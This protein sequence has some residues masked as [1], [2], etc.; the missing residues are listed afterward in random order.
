[1]PARPD[2]SSLPPAAVAYIEALEAELEH[3]RERSRSRSA[4]ADAGASAAAEPAEP[5]TTLQVITISA[6]GAA[7]R[8][9]RH[10]YN[11]QRRGGMGVFDLETPET[12]P[13][14]FLLIADLNDHLIFI[15]TRARGLR[16]PVDSLTETAVRGRGAALSPLLGLAAGEDLAVVAPASG[17]NYLNLLTDRG[18]V[19]RYAAHLFGP[20]MRVGA[21]LYDVRESGAPVA[22]CWSAGNEDLLIATRGGQA[23]RF[24][25][26]LVPVRGCL[27]IRLEREDAPRAITPV[28][29]DGVL[30]LLA[31]DGKGALREISSFRA[32]KAPGSGGKAI[33]KT[34]DLIA[35][36]RVPAE[37]DLFLISRLSKII[38]FQAGEVSLAG[39]V[40]QGVNCMELRSDAVVAA[41]ASR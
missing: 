19:R 39:G 25:E 1:M 13:P 41:V 9:P 37:A 38:R 17:G 20:T 34:D 2:L 40:V 32:N 10:L 5:P 30:F 16:L 6:D 36:C 33:M 12:A 8:T 4:M 27:G 28:D 29:D 14:T 18:Q 26:Q 31:G 22:A 15:T 35:A 24:A 21:A 3:L 11:R 7:K 23:I